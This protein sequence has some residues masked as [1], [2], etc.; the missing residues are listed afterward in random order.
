MTFWLSKSWVKL[1]YFDTTLQVKFDFWTYSELDQ[2]VN[3]QVSQSHLTLK[4]S[5]KVNQR[6]L[7]LRIQDILE[8]R[9]EM[10]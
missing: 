8:S 4:F 9:S 2:N 6:Y 7:R 10:V 1:I 3:L 5:V